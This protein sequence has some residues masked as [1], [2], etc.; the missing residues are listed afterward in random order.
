MKIIIIKGQRRERFPAQ[1][2]KASNYAGVLS[3]LVGNIAMFV[4]LK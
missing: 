4:S 1:R 2:G 3:R